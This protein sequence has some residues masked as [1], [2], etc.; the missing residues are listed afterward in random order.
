VAYLLGASDEY[1]KRRNPEHKM[2]RIPRL[3]I[4]PSNRKWFCKAKAT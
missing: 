3:I 1:V 2:G 4:V